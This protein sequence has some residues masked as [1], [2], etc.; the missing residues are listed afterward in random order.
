MLPQ[1]IQACC[2]VV[3]GEWPFCWRQIHVHSYKDGIANI[4]GVKGCRWK[5]KI[6]TG[7]GLDVLL[8]LGVVIQVRGPK[9][10]IDLLVPKQLPN[11]FCS[12]PGKLV[13][14]QIALR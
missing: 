13:I 1:L 4:E 7:G 12:I 8:Q 3:D 5:S 11:G 2:R 9:I 6:G 10:F 14:L